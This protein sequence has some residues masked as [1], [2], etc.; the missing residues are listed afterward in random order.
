MKGRK[1]SGGRKESEGSK[2]EMKKGKSD[3]GD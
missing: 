2:E 1:K 3:R